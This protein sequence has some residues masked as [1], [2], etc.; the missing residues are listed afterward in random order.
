MLERRRVCVFGGSFNPPHIGHVFLTTWAL[1]TQEFDEIRWIPANMHA[2]GKDLAKFE[3]RLAMCEAATALFD[4]RVT[5]SD[6]ER[7]LGGESRTI[8]TMEAL[9][10]AE[11]ATSFTL[12]MGADLLH[13]L[14]TWERG[15]ELVARFPILALG[16]S[17]VG[18]T[19]LPF[20][21]PDISS[22]AVREA[23]RA[24]RW[25]DVHAAVPAAVVTLIR[26]RHLYVTP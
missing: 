5:V 11:P 26:E 23:L 21:L 6:I 19:G 4:E 2:F 22:R 9:A 17:G 20:D 15:S 13:Q 3:D 10:A 12:L 18:V 16:R 7:R 25:E 8:V 14:R 24:D 1:A